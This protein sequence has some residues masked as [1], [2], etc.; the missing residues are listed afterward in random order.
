MKKSIL[1]LGK[2]LNSKEQKAILGGNDPYCGGYPT[3]NLCNFS[4]TLGS[5][6]CELFRCDRQTSGWF[7]V[8]TGASQ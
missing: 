4:C 8:D 2:A 7:C 3:Y 6:T 1:S 5:S